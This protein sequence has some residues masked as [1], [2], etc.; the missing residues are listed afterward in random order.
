MQINASLVQNF[1]WVLS[2]KIRISGNTK[3]MKMQRDRGQNDL[4]AE[5]TWLPSPQPQTHMLRKLLPAACRP[6]SAPPLPQLSLAPT[7]A[8]S[9]WQ[10]SIK[11][12]W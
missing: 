9:L 6:D 4:T 10:R 2:G 1:C 7:A 12:D 11:L 8:L 3:Q 5:N